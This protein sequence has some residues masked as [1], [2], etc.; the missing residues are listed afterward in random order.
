[1]TWSNGL[2]PNWVFD[3]AK[4]SFARGLLRRPEPACAYSGRFTNGRPVNA[5]VVQ[6]AA[7]SE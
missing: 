1:M 3:T 7:I 2:S 6:N 4:R 5:N